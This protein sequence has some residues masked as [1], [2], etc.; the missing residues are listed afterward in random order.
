MGLSPC[1]VRLLGQLLR[2]AEFLR[3][4]PIAAFEE[5]APKVAYDLPADQGGGESL[6]DFL[7]L[8]VFLR[9][10]AE[11]EAKTQSKAR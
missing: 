1:E 7:I 11:K 2:A 3:L 4:P 10:A 9:E 6:K 8:Y 5:L